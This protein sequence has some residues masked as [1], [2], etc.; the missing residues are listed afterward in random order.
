[1]CRWREV[2]TLAIII[3]PFILAI[4]VESQAFQ[5][6]PEVRQAGVS[7]GLRL[8]DLILAGFHLINVYDYIGQTPLVQILLA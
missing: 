8:P 1:M 4:F 2:V 7:V 6:L 5:L 3:S